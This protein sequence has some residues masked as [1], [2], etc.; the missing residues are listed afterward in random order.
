MMEELDWLWAEALLEGHLCTVQSQGMGN[1]Y[2]YMGREV[3]EWI[4]L[5]TYAWNLI[6]LSGAK[7]LITEGG[8][9][10]GRGGGSG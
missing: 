8:G 5:V 2:R 6:M 1:S 7:E 4:W 3:H 10:P 9:G